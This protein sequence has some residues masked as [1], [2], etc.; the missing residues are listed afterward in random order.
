MN[1]L[2][3]QI[4]DVQDVNEALTLP[5]EP[6]IITFKPST[7]PSAKKLDLLS[8]EWRGYIVGMRVNLLSELIPVS[9]ASRNIARLYSNIRMCKKLHTKTLDIDGNL[10]SAAGITAHIR[11]IDLWDVTV[12]ISQTL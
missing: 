7:N 5:E 8:E 3:T 9:K 1:L 10:P 2:I 11:T 6:T 4:M 12:R